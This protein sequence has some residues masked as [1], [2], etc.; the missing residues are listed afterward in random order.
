MRSFTVIATRATR[1]RNLK[2]YG[3]HNGTRQRLA[4]RDGPP[5]FR[6]RH[7]W[8]G[9][10]RGLRVCRDLFKNDT[11]MEMQLA[12][13]VG[14]PL[15]PVPGEEKQLRRYVGVEIPLAAASR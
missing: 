9:L 15:D 4:S 12:G 2:R 3:I 5:H 8:T 14:Q 13:M 11:T 7:T 1:P 6:V 10:G